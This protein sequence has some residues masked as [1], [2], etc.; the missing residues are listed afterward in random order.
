MLRW[1]TFIFLTVILAVV[2][3]CIIC[4]PFL[5]NHWYILYHR[6]SKLPGRIGEFMQHR[7]RL[8]N[9]S[10]THPPRRVGLQLPGS[11]NARRLLPWVVGLH[12]GTVDNALSIPDVLGCY[13][14]RYLL[15]LCKIVD[16]HAIQIHCTDAIIAWGISTFFTTKD[17]I[18]PVRSSKTKSVCFG[19]NSTSALLIQWLISC[20]QRF[21]RWPIALNLCLADGVCLLAAPPTLQ[22]E[23]VSAAKWFYEFAAK[24]EIAQL[25]P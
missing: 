14:I 10:T 22:E 21:S 1:S 25:K 5:T 4:S 16:S 17:V 23:W 2:V 12:R 15:I 8:R 19:L 11:A 9:M 18:I 24:P 20:I 7:Y 6:I 13:C 3:I